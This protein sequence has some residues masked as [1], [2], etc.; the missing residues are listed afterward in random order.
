MDWGLTISENITFQLCWYIFGEMEN[1][2]H[3][4]TVSSILYLICLNDMFSQMCEK[5]CMPLVELESWEGLNI[6]M[7]SYQCRDPR[8]EDTMVSWLFYLHNG[9]PHTWKDGLYIET[10]PDPFKPSW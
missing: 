7:V 6:K 9:N 5:L 8:D 10:G 3:M 1:T 4:L 2:L